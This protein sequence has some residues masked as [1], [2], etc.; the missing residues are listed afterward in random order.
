[1]FVCLFEAKAQLRNLP[2]HSIVSW[3][4]AEA[5]SVTLEKKLF[6]HFSKLWSHFALRCRVAVLTL[7][8]KKILGIHL[9]QIPMRTI[10]TL[11]NSHLHYV[12]ILQDDCTITYYT[13]RFASTGIRTLDHLTRVFLPDHCIPF[14]AL[15]L[16]EFPPLVARVLCGS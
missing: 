1:M 6:R 3:S 12:N 2:T 5:H 10:N 11:F 7:V 13:G 16:P 14:R 15:N 8:A 4:R 9:P